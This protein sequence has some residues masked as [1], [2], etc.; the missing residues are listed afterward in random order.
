MN[1]V[2]ESHIADLLSDRHDIYYYVSAGLQG[3]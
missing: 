3:I 1:T 2:G